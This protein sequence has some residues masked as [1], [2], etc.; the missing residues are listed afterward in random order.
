MTKKSNWFV[1]R[2]PNE[3]EYALYDFAR[4]ATQAKNML[5]DLGEGN[6]IAH[7]S[8]SEGG[9][10]NIYV[11][12]G[13]VLWREKGGSTYAEGGSVKTW[14]KDGTK[15]QWNDPEEDARDLDRV[16]VIKDYDG[17]LA[18][19]L[20][21]EDYEDFLDDL[22][23]NIESEDGTSSAEVPHWEIKPIGSTYAKGGEVNVSWDKKAGKPNVVIN[24]E[25]HG[26]I[27]SAIEYYTLNSKIG[28]PNAE[29]NK[30]ILIKLKKL[31]SGSTYAEGGEVKPENV[32]LGDGFELVFNDDHSVDVEYKG[33]GRSLIVS[34][35]RFE[36]DG[37]SYEDNAPDVPDSVYEDAEEH[38]EA[39]R[40]WEDSASYAEGGE[41]KKGRKYKNSEDGQEYT[42]I[43]K[44]EVGRD[45][46]K[47][48][49]GVIRILPLHKMHLSSTYAGGGRVSKNEDVVESFLT[50]NDEVNTKNLSTH[51]STLANA[52]LLRNYGTLIA[53]R[54]GKKVEITTEKFS[55]TT[56]VIQNMVER[57]AK[58][59]GLKVVKVDEFKDGGS[60]FAEGGAIPY[61]MRAM[62]SR[63]QDSGFN[64][65]EGTPNNELSRGKTTAVVH[66]G[67]ISVRHNLTDM[68][69]KSMKD[70]TYWLKRNRWMEKG[71]STTYQGGGE[72]G[73]YKIRGYETED[74]DNESDVDYVWG[75]KSDAINS[76]RQHWESGNYDL[77]VVQM[78]E[79][80]DEEEIIDPDTVFE[81]TRSE[82]EYEFSKGGSTTYQGGGE[83]EEVWNGWS[84]NQREHFLSDHKVLSN[85]ADDKRVSLY[86]LDELP[87]DLLTVIKSKIKEHIERGSY[88]KGGSTYAE[89]GGIKG[90]Y[91]EGELSFLNY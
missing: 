91:F 50:L 88:K 58:L 37:F 18:E 14:L 75:N 57:L 23:I 84:V 28:N 65:A 43:G 32:D 62:V 56:T 9:L 12:K 80:E 66:D 35:S 17:Q 22:I 20:E 3:S 2:K 82:G 67:E 70:L 44:D 39:I 13:T 7:K 26:S 46:F 42:S 53:V 6:P 60:V 8:K 1:T 81:I 47:G 77:I 45:K 51:F 27:S 74:Y 16:W 63:L 89:G 61:S 85:K 38:E 83:V 78:I 11:K 29:K 73:G 68:T 15:V 76:A 59:K 72:I 64:H 49:D 41:V 79:D 52:V 33:N 36:N 71:G 86:R 24:G 10:Y 69:F 48:K 87:I 54:V 25:E 5:R 34:Y 90:N 4:T 30:V 40:A 31:K 19:M 21:E 55:N